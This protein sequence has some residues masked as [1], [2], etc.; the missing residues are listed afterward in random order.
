MHDHEN[1]QKHTHGSL[2][3]S[4]A[5]TKRGLWAVKYSFI[6][7]M[8]T[9]FIQAIV[10]IYSGSIALLAD[11]IH[12]LGDAATAI[13]LGIAFL[14]ALKKST[15]RFTYGFGRIED[16]AG[17]IIVILILFSA[18][19][20]GYEAIQRIIYPKPIQNI[21][22]V[23]VA[24][25]AGFIGNETV[26]VF[27]IK[28][29]K[30]IGSAALIADGYHARIDGFTSL[31]VLVGAIGVMLGFPQADPI[32]GLLI[33]VIIIKIAWDSAKSVFLRLLDGVEPKYLNEIRHSL[34]HVNGVK[35][36]LNIKARWIGHQLFAEVFIKIDSKLSFIEA[37]SIVEQTESEIM[38]NIKY[39]ASVIVDTK[40]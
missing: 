39:V 15:K 27:R 25:L 29:G 1:I 24:S 5:A 34:T 31:A 20:A 28:I 37:H 11:T 18:I 36:V 19:I 10:F 7:L 26:A 3:P 38:R 40:P 13:P 2:D 17:V 9:F 8:I 32:V 35:D 22:A 14:F 33:T 6:W 16:L 12:N 21:W 4:I 23:I 30:E